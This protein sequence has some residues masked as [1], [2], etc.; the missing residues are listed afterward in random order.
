[1]TNLT[2]QQ[3][4]ALK[5]VA[6][7]SVRDALKRDVFPGAFKIGGDRRGIWQIPEVEVEAWQPRNYP[8]D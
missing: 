5:G 6:V 2:V 8:R 1:M 7:Q 3:A 4:A